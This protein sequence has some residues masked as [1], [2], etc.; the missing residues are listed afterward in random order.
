MIKQRRKGN[1]HS[2][3]G[4]KHTKEKGLRWRSSEK[5]KKIMKISPAAA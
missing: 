1:H 3:E 4:K 5:M 2:M